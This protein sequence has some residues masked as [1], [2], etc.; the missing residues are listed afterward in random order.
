MIT[1]AEIQNRIIKSIK[2]SGMTYTEIANKLNISRS[3]ISH[4]VRGDILPA[5]DTLANLCNLLE[6]DANYVL[7]LDTTFNNFM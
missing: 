3:S 2:E 6:I 1:I 4:F 7:C 5:L